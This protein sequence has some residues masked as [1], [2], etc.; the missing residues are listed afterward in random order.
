ML[1]SLALPLSQLV[2]T[3]SSFT[4]ACSTVDEDAASTRTTSNT[5]LPSE[6][7]GREEDGDTADMLGGASCSSLSGEGSPHCGETVFS[8]CGDNAHGGEGMGV[9]WKGASS[10]LLSAPSLWLSATVTV[11]TASLCTATGPW[12]VSHD[13]CLSS[14]DCCVSSHDC[15]VTS[16]DCCSVSGLVGVSFSGLCCCSSKATSVS[17]S[18]RCKPSAGLLCPST[19]ISATPSLHIVASG[20]TTGL[21]ISSELLTSSSGA[22]AGSGLSPSVVCGG[23]S[24][25]NADWQTCTG[26]HKALSSSLPH[27]GRSSAVLGANG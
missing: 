14:H 25:G 7:S 18:S 4:V 20:E 5:A 8:G 27:D 6:G 3:S 19:S 11:P 23:T 9:T 24:E 22:A 15:S 21:L 17:S 13:C 2:C 1:S 16:H 12:S 10:S 26:E